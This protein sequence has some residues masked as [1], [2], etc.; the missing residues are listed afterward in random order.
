MKNEQFQ[1]NPAFEAMEGSG[2]CPECD[3]PVSSWEVDIKVGGEKVVANRC[4][5]EWC[6]HM[7]YDR[8]YFKRES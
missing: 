7:E 8:M 5:C 1:P 6:G 3:G 4:D 2:E